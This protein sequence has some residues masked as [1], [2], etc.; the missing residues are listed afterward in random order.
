VTTHY[1]PEVIRD[2]FG[3]G[4]KFGMEI[5]YIGEEEPRGTAGALSMLEVSEEPIIVMNGDVLT[6][7]DFRAM[8]AFHREHKADLTVAVRQYDLKVPYGVINCEG[9]AVRSVE[10]KPI[11]KILVNAGIYI[12]DPLAHR[13]IPADGRFDMTDLITQ[14]SAAGQTVVAFP[15]IEYW[16]DVGQHGDYAQAQEDVKNWS[17]DS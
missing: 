8:L 16:L 12:L 6:R 5:E 7:V 4:K 10:E 15:V 13:G 2:H 11:Y 3:D 14:L 17:A 1:K 9:E